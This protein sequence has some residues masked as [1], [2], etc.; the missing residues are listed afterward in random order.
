MNHSNALPSHPNAFSATHTSP[1]TLYVP[2]TYC[3]TSTSTA[4]VGLKGSIVSNIS[5]KSYDIFGGYI[6]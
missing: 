5:Y 4:L 6:I 3:S 2:V 1:L